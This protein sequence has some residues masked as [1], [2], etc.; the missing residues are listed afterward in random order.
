MY[1]R[2]DRVW[3]AEAIGTRALPFKAY[4]VKNAVVPRR[5]RVTEMKKGQDEYRISQ[6]MLANGIWI[7]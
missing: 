2:P 7:L 3:V 6:S 1:A 5:S 4:L